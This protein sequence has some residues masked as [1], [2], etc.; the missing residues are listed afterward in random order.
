LI[1]ILDDVLLTER[2]PTDD[3]RALAILDDEFEVDTEAT[4]TSSPKI[5]STEVDEVRKGEIIEGR[6]DGIVDSRVFSRVVG[7]CNLDRRSLAVDFPESPKLA[8][9]DL[10]ISKLSE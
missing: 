4:S 10:V 2:S 3:V 9:L 1:D 7:F 6:S 5:S 8:F